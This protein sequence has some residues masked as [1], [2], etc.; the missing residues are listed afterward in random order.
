MYVTHIHVSKTL[1][2]GH[3]WIISVTCIRI[4]VQPKASKFQD[5]CRYPIAISWDFMW[6]NQAIA[7]N[8]STKFQH[9]SILSGSLPN[10]L[11]WTSSVCNKNT[12]CGP[13]RRHWRSLHNGE[14]FGT[15]TSKELGSPA[16][17]DAMLQRRVVS[18]PCITLSFQSKNVYRIKIKLIRWNWIQNNRR[19]SILSYQ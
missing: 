1:N 5:G 16:A 15:W 9:V 11:H 4:Y 6:V 13:S 17:D 3:K 10:K 18:Q 8:V 19:K 7:M 2:F 14:V 12:R